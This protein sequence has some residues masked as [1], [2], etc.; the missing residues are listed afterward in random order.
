MAR[1]GSIWGVDVMRC[2]VISPIS[3][4]IEECALGH[5]VRA[6]YWVFV[7]SSQCDTFTF[8]VKCSSSCIPEELLIQYGKVLRL[9]IFLIAA[10]V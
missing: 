5:T 1:E 4:L 7:I 8:L 10:Q 2:G 9:A 3:D 6:E